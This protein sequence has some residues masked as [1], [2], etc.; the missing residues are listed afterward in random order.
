LV[1]SQKGTD[2]YEFELDLA[3]DEI[4]RWEERREPKEGNRDSNVAVH[5]EE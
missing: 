2:F 1:L 4:K 5:F 3:S